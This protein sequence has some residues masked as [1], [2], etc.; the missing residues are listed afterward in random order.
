MAQAIPAA[1]VLCGQWT[2]KPYWALTPEQN[3]RMGKAGLPTLT[4]PDGVSLIAHCLPCLED[5]HLRGIMAQLEH[6]AIREEEHDVSSR[7]KRTWG[8]ITVPELR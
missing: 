6:E 8:V 2:E 4:T 3:S 7:G 1:C 5:V